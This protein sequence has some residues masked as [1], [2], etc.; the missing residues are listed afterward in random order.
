[1]IPTVSVVITT[2]YRNNL[3]EGALQ[4]VERQTYSQEAIEVIV[5]DASEEDNALPVVQ[6]FDA[7]YRCP[8]KDPG[9][10]GCRDIGVEVAS[11]DFVRFLDDDDRLISDALENQVSTAEETEAEVV[12]GGIEWP[13]GHCV[14]P[15]KSV[16]GDVLSDALAFKMAPCI[17]STQLIRADLLDQIPPMRSLPSDDHSLV[18][19]LAQLAKYEFVDGV[20]IQRSDYEEGLGSADKTVKN[21]FATIGYYADLYGKY[22]RSRRT[23]LGYSYLLSSQSTLNQQTWSASAIKDAIR[24]AWYYPT[25]ETI[26]FAAASLGGRPIRDLARQAYSLVQPDTHRGKIA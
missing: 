8:D 3:L 11:G 17:P 12:Y 4:S 1:M 20:V 15:D 25:L 16:R 18:I 7:K 14:L 22:P 21:R 19:E 26:G 13:G 5:V 2:H 23:A 9:L 6:Q 24:A 10:A